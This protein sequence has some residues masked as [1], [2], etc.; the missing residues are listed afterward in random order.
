VERGSAGELETI[1]CE[2]L[3]DAVTFCYKCVE[4]GIAALVGAPLAAV[5]LAIDLD[6]EPRGWC[7]EVNDAYPFGQPRPDAEY[8][9]GLQ[10]LS[11]EQLSERKRG[12]RDGGGSVRAAA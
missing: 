8:A 12:E 2:S 6:H 11:D 9:A 1:L 3:I 10:R 4:T 5:V 7:E